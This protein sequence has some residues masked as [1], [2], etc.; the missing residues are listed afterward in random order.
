MS[1]CQC[2]CPRSPLHL[3]RYPEVL[4]EVY[5]SSN[6]LSR[7]FQDDLNTSL[8]EYISTSIITGKPPCTFIQ[9]NLNLIGH[10]AEELDC[11]RT[12]VQGSRSLEGLWGFRLSLE[13]Q[14]SM[15]CMPHQLC[16]MKACAGAQTASCQVLPLD[17][18]TIYSSI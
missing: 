6:D 10:K 18:R 13:W 2:T 14:E 16:C 7:T 9:R 15:F 1:A 11:C 8:Q 5:V 3:H 4:P 12:C 17:R